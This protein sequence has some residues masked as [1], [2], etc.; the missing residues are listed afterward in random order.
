MHPP[1]RLTLLVDEMAGTLLTGSFPRS[2]ELIEA[3]RAYDRKRL[4]GEALQAAYTKDAR[5]V[6]DLQV[7]AGLAHVDDGLLNWQDLLRPLAEALPGVKLAALTRWYDNNTF[8]RKPI[9]TQPIAGGA[10]ISDRYY[11]TEV[12]P[13]GK[14]W[15]AVM[16]GPYTFSRLS[17]DKNYG[18]PRDVILDVSKV[19][20]RQA[21]HL[22]SRGFGFIQISE[23]S[24]TT[25]PPDRDTQHVLEGA[26]ASIVRGLEAKTLLHTYFGDPTALLDFL[27]DLPT[28]YLGLDFQQVSLDALAHRDFNRGLV[29]GLMDARNSPVESP[30][31]LVE[32]ARQV[33]DKVAPRDLLLAPNAELEFLPRWVAEAK[34]E[35]LG[36]AG[37]ALEEV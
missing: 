28:S 23:P 17:E 2:D 26:L 5:A 37:A 34:L 32:F 3:T 20:A 21:R 13:R 18:N 35:A 36:R 30:R 22:Q 11:R 16:P 7:K 29:V 12:L 9:L 6:V 24:L 8:Y 25:D 33:Q 4:E 31:E 27:L 19:L 1:G 14:S 10:S 15:R